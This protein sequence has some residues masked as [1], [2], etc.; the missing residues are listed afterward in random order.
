MIST[1][2]IFPNCC[3]D[4]EEGGGTAEGELRLPAWPVYSPGAPR[5]LPVWSPPA[6]CR[7]EERG[8]QGDGDGDAPPCP[9]LENAFPASVL[10]PTPGAGARAA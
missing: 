4:R 3:R 6:S 10:A 5:P 7:E 9:P 2:K 1:S 8:S